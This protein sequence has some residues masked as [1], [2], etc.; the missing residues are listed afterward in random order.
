MNTRLV[1][2]FVTLGIDLA[3]QPARTGACRI[4]WITGRG[5]AQLLSGDELSDPGLFAA[6]RDPT[7]SRIAIDA[8]FGWPRA[9]VDAI[10]AWRDQG[11]WPLGLDPGKSQ[12][13]LVLRA[14]DLDVWRGDKSGEWKGVGR[15][16]LSVSADRIAFAAMRCARLVNALGAAEGQAIDRSGH[17]RV[18]EVYPEAAL[19]QWTISS[20]TDDSDAGGYKGTSPAAVERRRRLFGRLRDRLSNVVDL[21]PVSEACLA[22]DDALDAVVCA[23][24]ARA[25]EVGALLPVGDPEQARV[26]GWIRLPTPESLSLLS[27]E[28]PNR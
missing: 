7:V 2:P 8:P 13:A 14:T 24:V 21:G 6:M 11:V 23:L 18:L 1:P 4:T 15:G 25:A 10:G 16:P 20:A 19:R 12:D 3:S 5:A 28:T 26:E 27:G 22:S 17:G 9:F